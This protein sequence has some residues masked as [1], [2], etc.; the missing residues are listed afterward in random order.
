MMEGAQAAQEKPMKQAPPE[1][2]C[3]HSHKAPMGE[4]WELHSTL[5]TFAS[6]T[7][8]LG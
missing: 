6:K 2:S 1:K 8:T 5:V 7:A 3:S 4:S